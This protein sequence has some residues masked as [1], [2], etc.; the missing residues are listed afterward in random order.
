MR[1]PT[2]FCL[3]S[4]VAI[5]A[6]TGCHSDFEP[7]YEQLGIEVEQRNEKIWFKFVTVTETDIKLRRMDFQLGG[8]PVKVDSLVFT[9]SDVTDRGLENC[10]KL[11]DLEV[12]HFNDCSRVSNRG[13]K[14]LLQNRKLK[15]LSIVGTRVNDDGMSLFSDFEYLRRLSVGG[16]SDRGLAHIS[17][18]HNLQQLTLVDCR[19]NEPGAASIGRLQRLR[20]LELYRCK[21]N[22]AT[23]LELKRLL[24]GTRI[25]DSPL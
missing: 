12:L 6:L 21:M 25:V 14:V 19:I 4:V 3:L 17:K 11:T 23:R 22:P 13:L 1:G 24:P 9:E 10:K 15:E 5:C 16:I 18:L 8:M 2:R 7:I 20:T